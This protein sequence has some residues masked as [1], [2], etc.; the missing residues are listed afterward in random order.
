MPKQT[1]EFPNVLKARQ[2]LG[3][4][5]FEIQSTRKILAEAKD[6]AKVCEVGREARSIEPPVCFTL[7]QF[8]QSSPL[9]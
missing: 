6:A 2:L 7:N 4:V 5:H 1:Q 9:F 8:D 3:A